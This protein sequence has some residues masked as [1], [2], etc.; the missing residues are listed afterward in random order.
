MSGIGDDATLARRIAA[1]LSAETAR[2]VTVDGV[3][4]FRWASRG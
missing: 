3:R 1:Y 2:V 4:R